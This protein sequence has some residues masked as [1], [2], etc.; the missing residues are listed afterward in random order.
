MIVQ[1]A[2]KISRNDRVRP[3]GV[4]SMDFPAPNDSAYAGPIGVDDEPPVCL[5]VPGLILCEH[6]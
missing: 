1:S 6:P 4:D 2:T 5:D 3:R